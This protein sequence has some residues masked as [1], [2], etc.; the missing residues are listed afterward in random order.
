[1]LAIHV[2]Q[3]ADFISVH[4]ITAD[5]EGE[6]LARF[7]RVLA[8]T[9]NETRFEVVERHGYRGYVPQNAATN[10]A[11]A[12]SL[13]H[14]LWKTRPRTFADDAEGFRQTEILLHRV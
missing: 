11:K 3:L 4:G 9:E 14:Q 2:D 10:H 6:P 12:V 7:R 13:A 1:A 8:S 5:P